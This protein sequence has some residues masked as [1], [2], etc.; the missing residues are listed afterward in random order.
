MNSE[1]N[2]NTREIDILNSRHFFRSHNSQIHYWAINNDMILIL[3]D[4]DICTKHLKR[5]QSRVYTKQDGLIGKTET[6]KSI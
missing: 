6:I 3:I 1:K 4:I 5:W 2:V